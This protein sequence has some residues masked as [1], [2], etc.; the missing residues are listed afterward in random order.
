MDIWRLLPGFWTQTKPLSDAWDAALNRA[1][2][3]HGITST[4]AHSA[5]VG[6][7]KVWTSNY[8]Y[9]F[10]YN[11]TDSLE[12]VPRVRTRRRLFKALRAFQEREYSRFLDENE[13]PMVVAVEAELVRMSSSPRMLDVVKRCAE[14]LRRQ[15]D[16]IATQEA[17]IVELCAE[18]SE[19][20]AKAN[21]NAAFYEEMWA[22]RN[23]ILRTERDDA[24]AVLKW[25]AEN[26]TGDDPLRMAEIKRVAEKGMR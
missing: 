3:V 9:A 16:K 11:C 20:E 4:D 15:N 2:D 21:R 18:R 22:A 13:D 14:E 8:P 10:G 19:L 25:I 1:L 6:P 5:M 12:Q 24:H 7:F 23:N 26:A 17:R